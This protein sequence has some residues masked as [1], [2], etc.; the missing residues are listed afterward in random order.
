MKLV[1]SSDDSVF[2]EQA[3]NAVYI[4]LA[5]TMALVSLVIYAF[6]GTVR[7]MIIPAVTIPICLVSAFI[8]LAMFDYSVNLITLLGLVLAIGLVVDDSIVVLENVQRRIE[9]GEPP[10]LAAVRGSRQVAF[11]VVATTLVLIAVFVPITFLDGN[12]GVLF[13]ELAVTIGTAVVFSSVL[14]L[15]LTTMMCSKLLTEHAHESWF[16]R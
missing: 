11:A 8:G 7:A 5:I 16:T 2:I 14:A 13:S 12:L 9:A 1:P 10:L 6:L 15:S 3:I 4:T